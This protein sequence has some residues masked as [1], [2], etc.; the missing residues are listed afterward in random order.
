MILTVNFSSYFSNASMTMRALSIV[1]SRRPSY[2]LNR[3]MLPLTSTTSRRRLGFTCGVPG[4]EK[5]LE[6]IDIKYAIDSF[7]VMSY[8]LLFFFA[9]FILLYIA[10][11]SPVKSF[12]LNSELPNLQDSHLWFFIPSPL[13][14]SSLS[15]QSFNQLC[16]IKFS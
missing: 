8:T 13:I 4:C 9:T 10:L 14:D 7:H 6:V 12:K 2:P 11:S 1:L 5:D 16:L 15:S 3:Y